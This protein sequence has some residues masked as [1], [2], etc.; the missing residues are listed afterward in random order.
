MVPANL[1]EPSTLFPAFAGASALFCVTD[2]WAPFYNTF[3]ATLLK[4]GQTLGQY[5]Y[6]KEL[7]QW[8]NIADVAAKIEGLERIVASSLVD[9]EKLSKGKYK[10]VYHWDSKARG[11]EYLREVYPE[12]A[13]KM[14]VVM[15]GNY[16]GNWKRDLKLQRVRVMSSI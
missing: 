3:T 4:E 11:V 12:L 13:K 9:A 15:M 16:M 2:F 1:D 8:K 14:T 10:G 6:E 7:R 5:C